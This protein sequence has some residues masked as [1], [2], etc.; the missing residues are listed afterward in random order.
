MLES[1]N[2]L[3]M[4]AVTQKRLQDSLEQAR[5]T[6][7]HRGVRGGGVESEVRHFLQNHLP[8]SL[9]VGTGEAIDQSDTR[10]GQL[11]IV[12][13]NEYQ[14]FRAGIDD[15]GLFLL[16]GVSAAGEVKSSLTTGTLQETIDIGTRFKALRLTHQ[17]NDTRWGHPGDSGRF[18]TCPPFFLIAFDN[19]VAPQTLIDRLQQAP[20]IPNETGPDLCP[21][22]AVFIPGRGRALDYDNGEGVV[23]WIP[24]EGP[25]AGLPATGWVWHEDDAVLVHLLMWLD[26]AMPRINRV[27]PIAKHYLNR[28]MRGPAAGPASE[29]SST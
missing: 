26:L 24:S 29:P 10:S 8:R 7:Q 5:A 25:W 19:H 6:F 23:G 22:D 28:A 15:P 14:P 17:E 1:P 4:L 18:Y 12:I 11:D 20:R 21:V 3:S 9:S 16:E 13:S 2:L 27:A